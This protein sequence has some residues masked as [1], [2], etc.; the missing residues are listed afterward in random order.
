[1]DKV[2]KQKIIFDSEDRDQIIKKIIEQDRID[3]AESHLGDRKKSLSKPTYY[4][5]LIENS[6]GYTYYSEYN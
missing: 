1:M 4:S 3:H 2:D 5:Q 6:R